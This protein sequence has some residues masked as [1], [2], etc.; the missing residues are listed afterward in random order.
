MWA[1]PTRTT[2]PIGIRLRVSVVAPCDHSLR[3]RTAV[4]FVL[5][6]TTVIECNNTAD[7]VRI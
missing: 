6:Y 4:V 2:E 5:K 3:V 7:E 1:N